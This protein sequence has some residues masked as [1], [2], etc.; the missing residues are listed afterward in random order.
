MSLSTLHTIK[1]NSDINSK[2][3]AY[4]LKP[5]NV[6]EEKHLLSD[7]FTHDRENNKYDLNLKLNY[8]SHTIQ[9]ESNTIQL[10]YKKIRFSCYC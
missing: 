5:L 8:G 10:V 9:Y 3:I 2:T 1:F 7:G 6:S 4:I